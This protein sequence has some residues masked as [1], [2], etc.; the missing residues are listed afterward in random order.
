VFRP[1]PS[2]LIR[3]AVPNRANREIA[4]VAQRCGNYWFNP[5]LV[6]R[7]LASGHEWTAAASNPSCHGPVGTP[8]WSADG[9]H[10]LFT[11]A[12]AGPTSPGG[13]RPPGTCQQWRRS[14]IAII[15]TRENSKL[16]SRNLTPAPPSCDYV[17]AAYDHAG[18]VAVESC[19]PLDPSKDRAYLVE[20]T[21][22]RHVI[23]REPLGKRPDG[24]SISVSP[25]GARTLVSEYQAPAYSPS[26]IGPQV[27]IWTYAHTQLRLIH[28]YKGLG[29]GIDVSW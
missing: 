9:A 3:D 13:P 5:Y 25:D 20:L 8:S 6:L 12:P 26:Y 29:T 14:E 23:R 28:T 15:P 27:T 19:G 4:Y 1:E 16:S 2:I 18:I 11:Y 10:V 21:L 24:I 17:Q 22:S 7:D